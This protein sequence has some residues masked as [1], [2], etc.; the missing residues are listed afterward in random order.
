MLNGPVLWLPLGASAP[1][2]LPDAVQAV[3]LVE[4]HVK[5]DAAPLATA[6]GAALSVTVGAGT[7]VTAVDAGAL[8]PLA[9]VHT[10]E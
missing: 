9:P 2:Q 7:T 1:L 6:V 5:V 3:A 10:S 8:V 4:L